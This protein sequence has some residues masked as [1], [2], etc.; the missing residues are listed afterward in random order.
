[1]FLNFIGF[2]ILFGVLLFF[3]VSLNG[4]IVILLEVLLLNGFGILV[5]ILIERNCECFVFII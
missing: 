1:M 3:V 2:K 4:F 5:F